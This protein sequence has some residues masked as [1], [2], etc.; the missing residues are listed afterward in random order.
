M[1]RP[2]TVNPSAAG[3]TNL[4]AVRPKAQPSPE[5][6]KR[7]IEEAFVRNAEIDANR[8]SVH[9]E[10]NT[11]ILDGTVRS[12]AEKQEAERAAWSAPGVA[13]VRN[14]ITISV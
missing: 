3:V 10:G 1:W 8:I 12:W 9:V 4:I 11:V 7:R 14:R 13:E 6:L 5:E 2:T